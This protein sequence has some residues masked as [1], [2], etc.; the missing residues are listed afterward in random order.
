MSSPDIT[1][2]GGS[3]TLLTLTTAGIL[4][5]Y[6]FTPSLY[7]TAGDQTFFATVI[8]NGTIASVTAK[9]QISYDDT[10]FIDVISVKSD[11]GTSAVEHNTATA[12]AATYRFAYICTEATRA[13]SMRFGIKADVQGGAGE[14]IVITGTVM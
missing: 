10:N 13:K 11:V 7:V 6:S 2:T 12:A 14:S 1:L 4:S 5:T 8:K 3:T 9:C